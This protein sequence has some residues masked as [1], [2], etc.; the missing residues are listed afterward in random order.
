MDV[1]FCES[2]S[3]FSS[4]LPSPPRERSSGMNE[5]AD[6]E[7]AYQHELSFFFPSQRT[8]ICSEGEPNSSLD[9]ELDIGGRL[10]KE[11]EI[12]DLGSLR[13]F[14]GIEV[15]R[16]DKGI[17]LS[18]QKYI[19]NLLEK[20]GMLGCRPADSPI[21]A[22]QHLCSGVGDFVGRLIYL[23]QTRPDIAYAVGI[24]SQFMREP[25]APHLDIVYRILRY[26]K[27]APRK[28][29]LFSNHGHLRLEAFTDADWAGSIDDRR[30]TSG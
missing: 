4:S 12:K 30:S 27:S 22:N 1:T 29:I 13:Y 14:L 2:V 26:L 25:C 16:S 6:K 10:D 11:F 3:F 8:I 24:V 18:Q 28:E 20:T 17:F 7:M 5:I 23:F 19:L 15:A 9:M 21:K